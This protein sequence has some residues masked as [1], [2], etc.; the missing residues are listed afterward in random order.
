MVLP[1]ANNP[2]IAALDAFLAKAIADGFVA[3]KLA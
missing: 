1:G 3:A 2:M